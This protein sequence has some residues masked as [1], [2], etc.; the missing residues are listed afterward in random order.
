MRPTIVDGRWLDTIP[1]TDQ[2]GGVTVTFD[3]PTARAGEWSTWGLRYKVV[4]GGMGKG[5]GIRVQL[6]DSWH[7]WRRCSAKGMQSQDPSLPNYVSARLSR[8]AVGVRCEVEGGTTDEYVKSSRPG[9][10]GTPHWFA[11][12]TRVTVDGA[13]QLGDVI[14][15]VYGDVSGGS[16]GFVGPLTV[17]GA[18]PV[19]VAV[20]S[21]GAGT[22]QILASDRSPRIQAVANTAAELIATAPSVVAV[23]ETAELHLAVLDAEGDRA[24]QLSG[25]SSI[26]VSEGGAEIASSVDMGLAHRGIQRIPFRATRPG[27]I[28]F[29]IRAADTFAV[30]SNPIDC[31][32]K[33]SQRIFWGDMHSHADHSF[34]AIGRSPYDYARDVAALDFYALSEHAEWWSDGTW[35]W[36]RDRVR[37]LNDPGRFVTIL[38]YEATFGHP[39]G[40]HNVYFRSDDGPVLGADRGTFVDLWDA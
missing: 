13:L 34:D 23:G 26:T 7:L 17:E 32:P 25:P 40:H 21:S 28:R 35:P 30:V 20:D 6:P 3:P 15:I 19:Q 39:W 22:H 14:E 12:V 37:K 8:A 24:T 1:V 31:Q 5:G 9:I 16:R 2:G 27:I 38:G 33:V 11:F 18:E 29:R 4:A 10:D 36:L